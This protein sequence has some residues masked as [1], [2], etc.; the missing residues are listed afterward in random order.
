MPAIAETQ[1][2]AGFIESRYIRDTS[3]IRDS[4]DNKSSKEID[5]ISVSS[6]SRVSRHIIETTGR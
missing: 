6:S 3:N 1:A 4:R 5:N 2:P